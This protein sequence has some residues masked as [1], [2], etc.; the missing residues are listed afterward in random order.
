MGVLG[1]Y[2][3]KTFDEAKRRPLYIVRETVN[4]DDRD[5]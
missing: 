1:I 3:G 5:V 4:F 2:I